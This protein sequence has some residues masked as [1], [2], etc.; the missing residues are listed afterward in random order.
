MF[1]GFEQD[2]FALPITLMLMMVFALTTGILAQSSSDQFR[3]NIQQEV[4]KDSFF[5]SHS[6]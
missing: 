3:V 1:R 5:K 2:G 4:S 6:V